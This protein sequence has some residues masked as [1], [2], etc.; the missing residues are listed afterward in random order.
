M[1]LDEVHWELALI[2]DNLL[3][4][5]VLAEVLLKQNVTTVLLIGQDSP[6]S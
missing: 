2:L 1:I 5:A 3:G 6:N 4:D